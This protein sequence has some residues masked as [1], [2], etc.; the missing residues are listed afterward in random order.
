M[1][2]PLKERVLIAED[3]RVIADVIRFNLT[4]AG[5]E[6]ETVANGALAWE[7][8]LAAPFD[9]LITD[10]QMPE[11]DGDELCRRLRLCPLN[12]EIPVILISS[13]GFELDLP[14]IQTELGIAE[15]LYKPFSP[16]QIVD[17]VRQTLG[18]PSTAL[19]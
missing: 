12:D 15:V 1:T 9:L 16:R 7:R 11:L 3:S 6:V 5:Y 14:A 19:S 18:S 2:S 10:F 8:L 13:K 17:L 4:R